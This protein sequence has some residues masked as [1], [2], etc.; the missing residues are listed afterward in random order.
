MSQYCD[1]C[2]RDARDTTV[3]SQE[4]VRTF[5]QLSWPPIQRKIVEEM[6]C[7]RCDKANHPASN[8]ASPRKRRKYDFAD[9]H[10]HAK[11]N[12]DQ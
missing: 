2:G 1:N 4:F 11:G 12:R 8:A 7:E 6:W 5:F 3:R 10:R 9:D